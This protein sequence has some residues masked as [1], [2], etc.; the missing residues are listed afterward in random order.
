MMNMEDAH[1]LGA[2]KRKKNAQQLW[3]WKKSGTQHLSPTFPNL[4][5]THT[6]LCQTHPNPTPNP[7]PCF[8]KFILFLVV[9]WIKT[10]FWQIVRNFGRKK[11][12]NVDLLYKEKE[13][14]NKEKKKEWS[15]TKEQ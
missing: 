5:Q 13:E 6:K 7:Q 15:K 14:R 1:F 9:I 2:T 11:G 4:A 3:S 8:K 12:N 10:T